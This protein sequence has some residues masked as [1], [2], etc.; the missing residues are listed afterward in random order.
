MR[1]AGRQRD[2]RVAGGHDSM[3][4]SSPTFF[5]FF[6]AYFCC[7]FVTPPKYRNYLII[8]GSTIFYAWWKIEYTWIPYLLMAI[9]YVGGYFVGRARD[10]RRRLFTAATIVALF[11]PLVIFKYTDFLYGDVLGPLFGWNGK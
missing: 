10:R 3:L 1:G 9:A 4:F 11:A 2:N 8:V 5:V 6:L 7:H